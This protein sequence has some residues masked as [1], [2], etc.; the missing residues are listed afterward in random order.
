MKKQ[1]V[2]NQLAFKKSS[3]IELCTNSLNQVVGGSRTI[4][5]VENQIINGV[6]EIYNDVKEG[7]KNLLP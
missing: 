1:N 4:S 7:I 5:P 3:V 2:N 6:K